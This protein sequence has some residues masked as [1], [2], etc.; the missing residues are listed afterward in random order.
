VG[1]LSYVRFRLD[2]DNWSTAKSSGQKTKTA[3]EAWAI[4]YLATGQ[5]VLKEN[6]TF[7]EFADNF[8]A[9]DGP[10]VQTQLNKG[11]SFGRRHAENQNA[12]ISNYLIEE[13][14]DLKLSKID[15][16]II[17]EYTQE[18]VVEGKAPS[19]INKI[20]LALR[21]MLQ[22]AYKKKYLQKLPIIEMLP[23][24]YKERGILTVEEVK[25]L[26][27]SEWKDIRY[28][29]INLLAA[30]TGMRVG[31][32]RAL[33]RKSVFDGYL[34]VS[35]S[36]EKGHGLKGTKTGR[37]RY[38]PLPSKTFEALNK[39]MTLT[40]YTEPDDF[41]FYGRKR[42]APLDHRIIERTFY[43][44]L[45]DIGIDENQRKERSICFHSWRHRSEEV[46]ICP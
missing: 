26:F 27:A 46:D 44:A 25:R 19:T 1:S 41:I 37:S 6:I 28:Y 43:K 31:E 45:E 35:V 34:E 3:A 9:Y 13:F 30:T 42:E 40:P 4:K 18:L 5:V 17:E 21:V 2:D 23:N 24:K 12:I 22:Q 29:T 36:W 32:I 20:L 33:Q 16:E 39:V 10:Y 11:K 8:F 14:G 38:I 15:S 7:R